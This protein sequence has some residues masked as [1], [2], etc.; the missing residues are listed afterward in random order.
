MTDATGPLGVMPQYGAAH[1]TMLTV[2]A[3]AAVLAVPLG[4]ALRVRAAADT[5]LRAGGWLL[6]AVAIGWTLWGVLPGN[7]DLDASLPFHYTDA[8]RVITAVALITRAPWAIAISY[9]WGLT[10]NAQSILTPD[11]RYLQHPVPEFI[12]YWFAH[13]T[14]FVVPVLL[15][16][17]LGY[18]PTW[19]GYLATMALTLGWAALAMTVNLLLGTNYAYLAHAPSGRSVLDLLGGWPLYIA[20]EVLLVAGVFALMTWPWVPI[21][22]RQ[23]ARPVGRSGLIV[24]RPV[25]D[26]TPG[27]EPADEHSGELRRS[28]RASPRTAAAP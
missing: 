14:A 21:A 11:L 17:G 19:R 9:Y 22:R 6:M 24:Q 18:R 2:I 25:R 3:A 4:R 10:L 15:V 5:V 7:W 13:G 20:W 8:L 26:R 12:A 23:H 1:L 28:E 16:W 27:H